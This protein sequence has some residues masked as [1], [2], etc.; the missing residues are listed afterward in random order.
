MLF[1]GRVHIMIPHRQFTNHFTL[2]PEYL[3]ISPLSTSNWPWIKSVQCCLCNLLVWFQYIHFVL[4]CCL[5]PTQ[6]YAKV[7]KSE[8]NHLN[9]LWTIFL[10]AL[11]IVFYKFHRNHLKNLAKDSLHKIRCVPFSVQ[12]ATE[13]EK[14]VYHNICIVCFFD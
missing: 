4:K 14:E 12:G 7:L 2:I 13:V 11:I 6:S 8:E 3:C 1:T 5:T 10:F 9:S